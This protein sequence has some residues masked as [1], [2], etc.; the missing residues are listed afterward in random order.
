MAPV[1]CVV[2]ALGEKVRDGAL[3]VEHGLA[4]DLG[5]M[6][7]ED[8]AHQQAVEDTAEPLTVDPGRLQAVERVV[9]AAGLGQRS[10]AA[11]V[12]PPAVRVY[13]LGDVG[14]QREPAER[15]GDV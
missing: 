1:D 14:E 9:Q 7:R 3:V 6:R 10:R 2:V 5:R 15:P 8:R 11:M 13:V 4:A 12:R